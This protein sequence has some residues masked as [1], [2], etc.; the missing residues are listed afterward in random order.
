MAPSLQIVLSGLLT[1]GVPLGFA[2]RE[3]IVLRR[4]RDDDR[5]RDPAP[6]PTPMPLAPAGRTL[7]DCLIPKLVTPARQLERV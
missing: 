3:L 4:F 7:P 5:G 1:Y 2:I 6:D